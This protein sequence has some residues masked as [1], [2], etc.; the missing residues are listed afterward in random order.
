MYA[1]AVISAILQ[2]EAIGG[3]IAKVIPLPAMKMDRGH[4]K[5][6]FAARVKT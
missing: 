6:S 4:F 2:A 3:N 5:V 1:D